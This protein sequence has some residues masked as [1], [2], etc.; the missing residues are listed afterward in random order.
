MVANIDSAIWDRAIAPAWR[1]LKPEVARALLDIRFNDADM[2][3]MNQLAAAARDGSL[4]AE[5]RAE[6]DSYNRI[7]HVL[8]LLHSKARQAAGGGPLSNK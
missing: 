6:L 7:G 4:S 2:A 5:E 3:R 1:E 8:A